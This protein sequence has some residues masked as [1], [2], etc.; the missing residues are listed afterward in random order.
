MASSGPISGRVG[1]V[2]WRGDSGFCVATFHDLKGKREFIIV[3]GLPEEVRDGTHLIVE[4][5]W[6]NHPKFG[7]QLKVTSLNYPNPDS[8][9]GVIGFLTQ[10]PY[11]GDLRALALLNLF[12]MNREALFLTLEHNPT[13]LT[14]MLGINKARAQEIHTEYMKL[15]EAAD[16]IIFLKSFGFTDK[17]VNKVRAFA[18]TKNRGV[19]SLFEADP[20]SITDIR[21]FSFG[22]VDDI[23]TRS[24]VQLND[25]NRIR[26]G[27]IHVVDR[28]KSSGHCYVE[29][30]RLLDQVRELAINRELAAEK[31]TNPQ[32]FQGRIQIE[33]P[34]RVYLKRILD[35][36]LQVARSVATLRW[37]L[38]STLEEILG[39]MEAEEVGLH[40]NQ[41]KAVAMA[42]ENGLSIVTG[43]PG[44][45]K[46]TTLREVLEVVRGLGMTYV[47]CCAPTG[48]AAI[49]MKEQT[50]LRA[51][52]I[53]RLLGLSKDF[54]ENEEEENLPYD[55]VIVD[56]ASMVDIELMSALLRVVK[57]GA[58]VLIVGD[59]DQLPSVGP[60][61][62]LRDLIESKKIPV[63]R[64]TH[65]FRQSE[66]SWISINAMDI[67]DG[68]MPNLDDPRSE[69]FFFIECDDVHRISDYIVQIVN[70]VLPEEHGIPASDVQVLCPQRKTPIGIN[71][72]NPILQSVLNE[73]TPGAKFWYSGDHRIYVGD[74]VIHTR[75][76][77]ELGVMN[78]ESGVVEKI[79]GA[80]ADDG[81]VVELLDADDDE[82]VLELNEAKKDAPKMEKMVV[83]FGDRWVRYT[84]DDALDLQLAYAITIHKSQG[85]EY[86]AVVIPIHE[87]NTFMLT[88]SLVYT[89]ITRGK[90][91]VFLVGQKKALE[92]AVQNVRDEKRNTTLKS[93]VITY[94]H[95]KPR[96][97]KARGEK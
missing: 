12:D 51:K 88:R 93:R 56:E 44:T 50:G 3:G 79:I 18:V 64:L 19:R 74:K 23:A 20:Y 46:T 62:V 89:G 55:M 13:Y 69:D 61:C 43:G 53:H 39:K 33:H 97:V 38:D 26:A 21:G 86:Q 66:H 17:Q 25:P 30:D 48:K 27:I 37:K 40:P 7:K 60:G 63:T 91:F 70:V 2:R 22:M 5:E 81:T 31:L 32:S 58:R 41:L 82:G 49:R 52:T 96:I 77:Y 95:D 78:G 14:K 36:E 29:E 8:D 87:A 85:S 42:V 65:I 11:I 1:Y 15:R 57:E 80:E 90:K 71:E 24:G 94:C 45:G 75:N 76:N 59:V 28:E 83:N 84:R 67:R 16:A 54:D 10:L 34:D 6:V 35:A 92:K 47:A 9:E 68:K 72:I 73:P 4:G